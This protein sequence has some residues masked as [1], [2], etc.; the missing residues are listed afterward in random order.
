M[1]PLTRKEKK[2]DREQ[3]VCYIFKKVFGTDDDN[4]KNHKV[5]DHCHC[6]GKSKGAANDICNLR[7]KIPKEIPVILDN[8][9]TYD[10]HFIIK[11]L[12]E[13]FEG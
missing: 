13:K 3:K 6:T 7:Y 5:R 2:I 8:G 1:I 12:A 9:S 4:K 10:Y 11:E